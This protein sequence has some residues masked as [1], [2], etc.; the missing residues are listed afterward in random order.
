MSVFRH[1]VYKSQSFAS[2]KGYAQ[3]LFAYIKQQKRLF[4]DEDQI[5]SFLSDAGNAAIMHLFLNVLKQESVNKAGSDVDR[6]NAIDRILSDDLAEVD[7]ETLPAHFEQHDLEDAL[8]LYSGTL[9]QS[10]QEQFH[11]HPQ[12][13]DVS[14]SRLSELAIKLLIK[15]YS[16]YMEKTGIVFAG[17]GDSDYFP[18]YIAYDCFGFLCGKL[19]CDEVQQQS[20][21]RVKP[22][23]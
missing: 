4:S 22:Q 10:L 21:D 14:F 17:F 20:I 3:D 1:H 15:C 6:R 7:A 13:G 8:E 19:L 16:Q 23:S 5:A 12:V 9:K 11:D 18:T 2:L